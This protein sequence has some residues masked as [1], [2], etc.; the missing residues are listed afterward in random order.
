MC[1]FGPAVFCV[2]FLW[3]TLHHSICVWLFGSMHKEAKLT[4]IVC[5]GYL[6]KEGMWE[7]KKG[8]MYL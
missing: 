4:N 6:G 7:E 5:F 1:V 8:S 2:C 3:G